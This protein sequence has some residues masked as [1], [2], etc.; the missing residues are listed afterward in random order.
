MFCSRIRPLLVLLALSTTIP[1]WTATAQ[2]SEISFTTTEGTW[3]S[4]DVAPDDNSLVFELL[5]DIYALPVTGGNARPLLTGRAF[6]SQPRF[7]PDGSHLVYVSDESGSDNVWI[8]RSDGT[9]ARPLSNVRRVRMISP[10]WS[11]DGTAVYVTVVSLGWQPSAEIW[12]Y[13]MASGEGTRV[14]ENN[15]GPSAPLVSAPAPGP[16]GSAPSPD[17][18]SIYY[19]SVTPRP[20]GS[21]SGASSTVFRLDLKS[22]DHQRVYLEGLNAMRPAV[23]PDGRSL[24]YAAMK[25]GH[26]G[27][28]VRDLESGAERWLAYP[29]QRN[30]LEG[31]ATRDVL[32]NFAI[33]SDSRSVFLEWNGR[34]H[35][36]GLEDESDQLVPFEA[37]VALEVE[38][39][40]E[41]P[42]RVE[43]G[44]VRARRAQH[45][46]MAADGRVAFSTLARIWVADQNSETPR[47][48]TDTE[49]P[50]EFLPSWSPDG[51]WIA[52]VTWD[53]SGGH[54][55]K[56][57]SDGSGNPVRLSERSALWVDPTWTPDGSAI[58][59]L[60]APL[61]STLTSRGPVPPDAQLVVVPATGGAAHT[62]VPADGLRFPHFGTDSER[63]FLSSPQAGLISIAL[64]GSDR[65][66][67]ARLARDFGPGK[68]MMSPDGSYV[69]GIAGP[70]VIRFPVPT[71]GLAGGELT[72]DQGVT[73]TEDAPTSV[74][75][76]GDGSS[77]SW[78]V[79]MVLSSV[80]VTGSVE[81]KKTLTLRVEVPRPTPFGDL[82]LR[83]ARVISM[84]GYEIVEDGDVVIKDNRIVAV[85][86]RGAEPVPASARVV[87]VSGKVIV[88]GFIDIHAHLSTPEELLRPECSASFANLAYGITTIRDP[89]ANP[90]VFAVADIIEA[91]AVPGPRMYSTGPGLFATTDFQSLDEVRRYLQTYRDEYRTHLIKEYLVGTRQQ[92]QWIVQAARELGMMV[93]NEGGADTK[94]DLTHAMDGFSG[95]EHALPVAPIYDDVVQLY[96]RAGITWTPT[97]VVSFGAALPIYRLLAEE[98]PHQ[99]TK[100]NR[101][102][103]DGELFTRT[104]T[105]VL[106]FPP[107]DFNNIDVA[108]G[109][110]AVLQAGGRVGLGGHGELQGLSN[111][112]EMKLLADG[113]MPAHDILRVATIFSAQAIGFEQDLGS[114]EPGKLADL[115]VLDRDPLNDI[116]ATQSVRYVLKNGV[117]Y[118]GSTLDQVW[119]REE[120]LTLP[121]WLSRSSGPAGTRT[122]IDELVGRTLDEANIPGAAVAVVRGGEVLLAKGYG[123][124]NLETDTRVTPETM[125]Q[126]G[127]LGKQ[128]TSAGI[129]ALVEEGRIDLDESVRSYLP[130]TPDS[131][132]PITIRH[133]LTHSSGIPDYTSDEF[134][135]EA[136]Y[137][138]NDLV[139]IATGLELEFPAGSRWNYSNTG[140]VLL[141]VIMGRTT[142]K[143]YWEY[144]RER[145]FDPAGMP[146]I[147]VN[148]ASEIVRNRAE[149]YLPVEGGWQHSAYVAP[150]TNTTADGSMLVNLHD[151]IAWN[152]VVRNRRVLRPESW[153]T[154]LSPMTL[155]SGRTYPYGFGWFFQNVGGQ[156][157]HEHGG[158]WQG[159]ITQF[160]RFTDDD[161]A[162][163]VLSN[164][165]TFAVP[166]LANG[167]A[168]LVDP[169]LAPAPPATTPIP[170]ADTEATAYVREILAKVAR[171]DL[172]QDDFAFVRQTVFPRMR[173]ALTR[174]L[175]GLGSPDRMELLQ[176]KV[177]GDDREFQYWAWY[178]ERRFRVLVSL[179]PQGGLTALRVIPENR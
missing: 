164:G 65:R 82:V 124:A 172:E 176:T 112:W 51:R 174:T 52:F 56:T 134:D 152:E 26:T 85:G 101:W 68:L 88:P 39:R 15:N 16:Y 132:R 3:I 35:R 53:V 23:T 120:P 137:D 158:S 179:G 118:D 117:L 154:V 97:L 161:L 136:N 147:R 166:G 107:E 44:P 144:L 48:L 157:V 175:Q 171:G 42:R 96:A 43:T 94:A 40:L 109:V 59:A 121:W 148:T 73:V 78:L 13:D 36:L 83:G 153:E 151:M 92:R 17:G 133:L 84:R 167:I 87:D 155:S 19:T 29:I 14:V 61:G 131:W 122:A 45:L 165:R 46:A 127:S 156:A 62:V 141:G 71:E 106:W 37:E 5:G 139:R 58:V 9:G 169:S 64:D 55:W 10:V 22:G 89:Q 116:E 100:A 50:R 99:N 47:R 177:V 21:R 90:D 168:A 20:Y 128:F 104:A 74:A 32:P 79:G 72:V 54:L 108:R 2:T 24:V 38:P 76:D 119:P 57:R 162:I 6:Q 31:R 4:L 130:E 143:P 69:L 93:T 102:F 129:M 33:A 25:D 140:Y 146:T 103:G 113:G 1:S 163:I 66:T 27:L 125:F 145:I 160:T 63:V 75:W 41:F 105:R 95:N 28:K 81:K 98:Q 170:D 138:E 126:S 135:Y 86:P 123:V 149:G 67:E 34:I 115:V 30:Q 110:N 91:D 8:S 70:R 150:T 49:S 142:G 12:Q 111:H 11:V 60:T 18:S 80:D 77:L 173:V 114:L 7:S 178:G 159:F